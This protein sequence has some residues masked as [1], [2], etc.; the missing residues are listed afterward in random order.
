MIC[1]NCGSENVIVQSEQVSGKSG[2]SGSNP[3]MSLGR[4]FLILCTCGLWLLV[5]KHEGSAKIKYKNNTVGICQSC[6]K[7]WIINKG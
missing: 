1:P 2:I 5:P 7:K 6:G 3:L 4:M